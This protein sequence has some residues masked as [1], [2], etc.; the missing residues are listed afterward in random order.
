MTK[1]VFDEIALRIQS[2]EINVLLIASE[3]RRL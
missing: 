2:D 1:S 3:I